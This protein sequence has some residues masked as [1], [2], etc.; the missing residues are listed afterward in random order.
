VR[1]ARFIRRLRGLGGAALL[2]A[3][4]LPLPAAAAQ[5]T[6][7][8]ADDREL[9]EAVEHWLHSDE[10]VG[11]I[12]LADLA[13]D[14][15]AAARL[16]LAIID[17]TPA[18][19]GP[20][21]A[22]LPREERIALLRQPGGLSGR[23]WLHELTD[24]PL[25]AAWLSLMDPNTGPEV[26]ATLTELGEARAAREALVMLAA[27]EHPGLRTLDPASIDPDLIF[28]LWRG[29]DDDRRAE[30]LEHVTAG[31]A[32]HA[33]IEGTL[34]TDR[35]QHWL[36]GAGAGAPLDAI[37]A[38]ECPETRALCLSNAYRALASH[39]ALLTLGSP[40]EALVPQERFLA[41]PRGRESTLRRILQTHDARGRRALISQMR[42]HDAC[43]ADVLEA[44][45]A[46]YRYRRPGND[47][48]AGD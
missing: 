47:S 29:A 46:R 8:G 48:P 21:L 23:S 28:L 22:H 38:H 4:L 14:G 19:Q 39:N 2:G 9:T 18:L 12:A 11:L 6:I 41:T 30:L 43:L 27:R 15:N 31:G 16:L 17:K 25:G 35:L 36:T 26:V 7:P 42:E 13:H 10:D 45:A 20:W 44:E 32:Q 37:C 5:A 33:L 3:W 24:L 1:L 34:D 40:L